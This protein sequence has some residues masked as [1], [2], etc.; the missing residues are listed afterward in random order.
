MRVQKVKE[1]AQKITFSSKVAKF[2]V[3]IGIGLTL[4]FRTN[5]FFVRFSVLEIWS[6]LYFFPSGLSKSLIFFL[7]AGFAPGQRIFFRIEDPS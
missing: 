3:K 4:I 6:I 5:D 7:A 1:D 2:A